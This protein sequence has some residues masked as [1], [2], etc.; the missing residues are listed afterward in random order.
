MRILGICGSLRKD[1]TNWLLLTEAQKLTPRA[2][3]TFADLSV[4][5]WF[6]PEDQFSEK[7]PKVVTELRGL[8]SAADL[9]VIATPEY[10]H[11]MPGILKN[12]LE[13][14]F[15][16]GTMKKPVK[17]LIGSGQGEHT[18]T[19]L[20]ETLRTMDFLIEDKDAV[21]FTGL[22]AGITEIHHEQIRKLF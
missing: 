9:I 19:Q 15:C 8:A 16:E 5:P 12:G 22:R 10:A 13:W 21:I 4:L 2:Q 18:R 1:S 14:T 20:L 3:W 11:S 6:R 17:L 7:V